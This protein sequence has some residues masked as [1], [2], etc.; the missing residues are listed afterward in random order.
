MEN[1]E[2]SHF[3]P[4]QNEKLKTDG[5]L[6]YQMVYQRGIEAVLWSMPAMSDVF[7]RESLYRD[8]GMKPGD[9]MVMS[10]PLVARHEVLT[11]NNQ[12][13]YAGMPFDL[14]SGPF[15]VEIPASSAD[16]AIIGEI[17]DNWQAPLTMVGVEG[18]DA[19]KGGKYLLVPPGYKGTVPDGYFVINLE[20]FR[21]A[22]VFR[23]VV[24][25]KGTMA[26]SILL[27]HQTKTY[28]LADAA[29]PK[30]T[31]ILDGWDKAWHSLPVYDI[32]WFRYL[33]QFINEEPIR[34]RD[35]VMIGML[36]TLGIRKGEPFQP[37]AAT[38]K[39]L[40]A[41]IADAYRIMQEGWTTPGKALTAWWPSRQ[42]LNANPAIMRKMGIGW[43]FETADAVW[44]YERA[45]TPFFWANYLPQ[46]LGGQQ[47]YLM[48]M[49][50]AGGEL[51]TGNNSYRLHI[52]SDVPV[53]KFWSVIVYSQKTK[54]FIP[55]PLDR[56]GLDSYDKSK[57][58]MNADGSV[59][60][61]FG[62]RAPKDYEANLL[63]S[64]GEDFFL[65]FRFYG[66]SKSVYDKTWVAPDVERMTD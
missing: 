37:D 39:A 63:P 3:T 23:P 6:D 13:N 42:W 33:S 2:I 47:L 56:V 11:A 60:I 17:C 26:G 10:K 32:T 53:D 19:G 7:F 59:D 21:G 36:S 46:K 57:L 1:S 25:G 9:V 49:R 18:P 51:F 27:A 22:M 41:A 34:E 62:N 55:N 4:A 12:V 40:N 66:P 14:S 20:G 30:P 48:N 52:P 29:S 8:Y 45:I 65:I 54:S 43:S 58:K 31:I 15:V 44:T 24:I 5:D 35:K 64:A 28:P 61:Y 38:T 16:Y 50:D